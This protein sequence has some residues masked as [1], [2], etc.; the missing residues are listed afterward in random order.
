VPLLGRLFPVQRG[1]RGVHEPLRLYHHLT[2]LLP[3]P[4]LGWQMPEEDI[5][6]SVWWKVEDLEGLTEDDE[7]EGYEWG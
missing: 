1:P 5:E 3:F 4:K 2:P 6:F 7:G